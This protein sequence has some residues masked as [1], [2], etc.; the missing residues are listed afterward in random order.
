MGGWTLF[1]RC[2]GMG[3]GGK[4]DGAQK[5]RV[6][7]VKSYSRIIYK[8]CLHVDGEGWLVIT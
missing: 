6:T 3:V 1:L 4:W 2:T 7:L 5:A 8:V